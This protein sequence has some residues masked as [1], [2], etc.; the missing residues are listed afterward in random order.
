MTEAKAARL[1]NVEVNFHPRLKRK[2]AQAEISL[3]KYVER[4]VYEEPALMCSSN[5]FHFCASKKLVSLF[6]IDEETEK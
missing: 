1:I 4:S 2:N 3:I 5:I 6:L